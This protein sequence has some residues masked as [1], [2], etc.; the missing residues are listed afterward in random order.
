MMTKQI[1][2][3]QGKFTLVNDDMYEELSKHKWYAHNIGNTY[4]AERRGKQLE[5]NLLSMHRIILGLRHG[6]GKIAD[7]INRNGLDNRQSNLR[8]VSRSGNQHNRRVSKNNVSGYT[9][10][11]WLISRKKWEARI[12]INNRSIHLGFFEDIKDAVEAR[13]QG[14]L[15]YW[16]EE[17]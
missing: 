10:V 1:E 12:K 16:G 7:H 6:D 4:Y 17:K 13:R 3:T 2:L 14:E 8:V 9:G 11:C 15:K 5:G